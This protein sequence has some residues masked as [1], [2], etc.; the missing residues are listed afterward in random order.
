MTDF[1]GIVLVVI[2][3]DFKNGKEQLVGLPVVSSGQPVDQL[4]MAGSDRIGDIEKVLFQEFFMDIG[5]Y[6]FHTSVAQFDHFPDTGLKMLFGDQVFIFRLVECH[7]E[8]DGTG[9]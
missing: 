2:L 8:P 9:I 7:H 4:D 5:L 1:G 3:I 6:I